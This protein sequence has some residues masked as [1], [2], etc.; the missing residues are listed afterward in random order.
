MTAPGKVVELVERFD[1]N[2]D[3]YRSGRYNETQLRREFID[4]LIMS[5]QLRFGFCLIQALPGASMPGGSGQTW[6][7]TS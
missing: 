4:L 5:L 3:A 2:L 6:H 7:D 1:R